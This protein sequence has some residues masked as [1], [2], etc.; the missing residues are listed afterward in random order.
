MKTLPEFRRVTRY[1]N[2][3]PANATLQQAM[4][5][6]KQLRQFLRSDVSTRKGFEEYTRKELSY[7][8]K[9][10]FIARGLGPTYSV[11]QLG[12]AFRELNNRVRLFVFESH[13]I[14]S[15]QKSDAIREIYGAVLNA[16]DEIEMEYVDT[17]K[18]APGIAPR[19]VRKIYHIQTI[20]DF[21][22]N[23]IVEHWGADPDES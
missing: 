2:N 19:V 3:L 6:T 23:Y 14:D 10:G 8:D 4:S 11:D 12:V 16:R 5:R 15:D 9:Y 18:I 20:S 7:L 17:V 22:E 21:I 13:Q 1:L